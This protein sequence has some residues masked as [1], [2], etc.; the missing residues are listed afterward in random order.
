METSPIPEFE[1]R[2]M[3]VR[4]NW[5]SGELAFKDAIATLSSY[6]DEAIHSGHVA[7]EG[8]AEMV[9]G[10]I[11]HY[12]G[13]LNRS[14]QH[15]QRARELFA[16]LDNREF[17]TRIDLNQGENY[18]FKGDTSYALQLYRSAFQS[19]AAIGHIRMQTVAALNEGLLLVTAEQYT[20]ARRCF[21]TALQLLEKW[22]QHEAIIDSI[23]CEIDYGMAKIHL[24]RG[25]VE[26][27]WQEAMK[28]WSIAQRTELPLH[29]GFANRTIGQ[30][31]AQH[32]ASPDPNF[33]DDPDVY[34]AAATRAFREIN[35]EAEVA[36]TI[37]AQA[38]A[39]A[40]RG[41]RL[42]AAHKL[43][44]VTV[45]FGKLGMI[46]DAARAAEAQGRFL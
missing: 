31:V 43:Q 21:E 19:A 28:S 26:A 46:G 1:Q 44:Q 10:T 11:Q 12:R 18:R 4:K 29:I 33:E 14:I 22:P 13:N 20:A 24:Q 36:R 39:Q 23:L 15:Y 32:G 16:S 25:D 9:L 5:E 7:N 30:V 37:F 40:Q 17:T 3:D 45:I 2:C 8:M 35:A 41:D 6:R 27:A 38:V 42:E 34:F